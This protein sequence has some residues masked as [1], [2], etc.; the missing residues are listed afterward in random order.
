MQSEAAS[1]PTI[2]LFRPAGPPARNAKAATRLW[3]AGTAFYCPQHST[4]ITIHDAKRL[5]CTH[6]T[7]FCLDGK[8]L[9]LKL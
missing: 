9:T 2:H 7:I 5:R 4:F 6:V 1:P 3:R 8:A